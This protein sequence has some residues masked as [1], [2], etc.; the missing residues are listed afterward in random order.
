MGK[1]AKSNNP[2]KN[3]VRNAQRP[4][5]YTGR[6]IKQKKLPEV[7]NPNSGPPTKSRKKGF[8]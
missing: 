7:T 6:D 8:V 5:K 3:E 2:V 1:R 4:S